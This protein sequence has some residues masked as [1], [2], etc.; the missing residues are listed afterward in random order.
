MVE[1]IT[2]EGFAAWTQAAGAQGTAPLLLDVREPA[3]WQTASVQPQGA[4][5]RQW[6]MHTVPAR[7]AELDRSQPIAVL[8]HHGGRSMQVALFLQQQ[9]FDRLANVA[10]GI[11]AWALQLDPSVP[12]Y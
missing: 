4:A 8:C 1:Q 7:L 2:P 3:E 5:L 12:R 11:D 6:P 9:G 10:G